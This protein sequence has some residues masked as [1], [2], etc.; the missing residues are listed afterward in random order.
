MISKPDTTKI[1]KSQ[2]IGLWGKCIIFLLKEHSILLRWY[3]SGP[4]GEEM[5]KCH[6]VPKRLKEKAWHI[7]ETAK[8]RKKGEKKWS[9][10]SSSKNKK[11]QLLLEIKYLLSKGKIKHAVIWNNLYKVNS[12]TKEFYYWIW[13]NC[14]VHWSVFISFHIKDYRWGVQLS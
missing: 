9:F 6:R 13:L 8:D 14:I 1:A 3:T 5:Y 4:K 12:S 7:F 2:S 11:D 10:N